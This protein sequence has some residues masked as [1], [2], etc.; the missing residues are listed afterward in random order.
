MLDH[1]PLA[2]RIQLAER[3]VIDSDQRFKQRLHEVR[4][5]F[6]KRA[7]GQLRAR[8]KS[9]TGSGVGLAAAGLTTWMLWPKQQHVAPRRARHAS[10]G[11][12]RR[13][14]L[15]SSSKWLV[16]LMPLLLSALGRS[17]LVSPGVM[18]W[19]SLASSAL[20]ARNPRRR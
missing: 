15:T 16:A 7:K 11:A 14:R 12:G 8:L 18:S 6:G 2:Q 3:E 9:W 19:V 20:V 10:R 1:L 17:G 5:N 4:Q 13:G